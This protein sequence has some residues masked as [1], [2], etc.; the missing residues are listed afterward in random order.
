VEDNQDYFGRLV[1][2]GGI[3]CKGVA[4]IRLY[5]AGITILLSIDTKLHVLL[6]SRNLV[7]YHI[8]VRSY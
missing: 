1:I 5:N 2:S 8:L 4:G 6:N 3:H 7:S